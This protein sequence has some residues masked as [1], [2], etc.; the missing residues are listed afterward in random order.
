MSQVA[1]L[2][3]VVL[4]LQ[5]VNI[6]PG[7]APQY[8]GKSRLGENFILRHSCNFPLSRGPK[9][10]KNLLEMIE[11]D[12]DLTKFAEALRSSE[13]DSRLSGSD[14]FTVF[15]PSDE[16]IGDDIDDDVDFVMRHLVP[17]F[18][19]RRIDLTT[20]D[21]RLVTLGGEDLVITKTGARL[22]LGEV[23]GCD[24]YGPGCED[25]YW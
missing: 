21:T 23:T 15:A 1:Q 18:P 3:L 9:P 14:F 19:R 7:P 10:T 24:W 17:G 4:F 6:S 25:V 13:L 5:V 12:R 22:R 2:V 20:G 8:G 16:F 11:Q